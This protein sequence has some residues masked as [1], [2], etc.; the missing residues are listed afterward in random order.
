MVL[1]K[2]LRQIIFIENA[3][4]VFHQAIETQL[5][6]VY[7]VFNFEREVV[8]RDTYT[9]ALLTGAKVFPLEHR[10]STPN[11]LMQ[12]KVTGWT[13]FVTLKE[14]LTRT[15][16]LFRQHAAPSSGWS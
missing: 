3:C 15:L 9:I 14:G 4:S 7:E 2:E 6:R 12:G 11:K 13:S 10:G 5:D 8:C 1:G 16:A